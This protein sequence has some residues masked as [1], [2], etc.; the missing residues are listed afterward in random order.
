MTP[1]EIL[2]EILV[3]IE[4]A[5]DQGQ[6]ELGRDHTGCVNWL[7][8]LAPQIREALDSSPECSRVNTVDRGDATRGSSC[9]ERCSA[10]V[11]WC[12]VRLGVGHE[13]FVSGKTGVRWCKACGI[14]TLP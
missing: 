8:D 5:D 14:Q 6:P 1:R 2:A 12:P 4:R 13:W 11:E 3:E 9:M 10:A 7:L